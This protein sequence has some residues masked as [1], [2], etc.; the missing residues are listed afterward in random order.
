MH[1]ETL[2]TQDQLKA[3]VRELAEEIR[4]A[5]PNQKPLLVAVLKGAVIFLADL[6]RELGPGF[7]VD[8]MAIRT[9][10]GK[11]PSGA[12][13][14]R[15]DLGVDIKEKDVLLVEDVVD[16]GSTLSYLW[17]LLKTRKP[18]S[19]RVVTLLL[20]HQ[21]YTGEVPIDFV[22]FTIPNVFVVGYGLDLDE[23]WRNLPY[24]AMV[25]EG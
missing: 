24:L 25:K 4:R 22:G 9:Y 16:T 3:R 5:Y 17:N 14:I 23:E 21:V 19:L 10:E 8:F 1:L 18:R 6:M 2:I 20:K 11:E 15:L 12:V 7:P 13:E